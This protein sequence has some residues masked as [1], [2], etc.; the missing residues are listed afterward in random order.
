MSLVA[1]KCTQCG[2]NI[3]VDDSKEAGICKSCGTAFV[4]QK[5]INNYNI[6]KN[7]TKNIYGKEKTE[8]EEFIAN[9]DVFLSLK[10]YGKAWKAFAQ[11][12]EASPSDYKCWFGLAKSATKNFTDLTDL[13]HKENL[14]KALAV[15][16]AEEKEIINSASRK[17]TVLKKEY[18]V[19]MTE[20][21]KEI[22][23]LNKYD[24]LFLTLLAVCFAFGISLSISGF[25]LYAV[26]AM[27]SL[28]PLGYAGIVLTGAG[29]ICLAV[30][31]VKN[32]K[33]KAKTVKANALAA[34][35]GKGLS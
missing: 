32:N 35:M 22:K 23:K 20:L 18:D 7:I 1:A 24:I 19:K 11:A 16:N 17:Y 27:S 5:A 33:A 14:E 10:D 21:K 15:A 9:G 4:T 26:A 3:E 2:D 6:T 12:A 25:I 13:S 31:I 28:L 30:L 29:F 8:A 34:E